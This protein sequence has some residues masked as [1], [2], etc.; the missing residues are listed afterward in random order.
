MAKLLPHAAILVNPDL[1]LP[2]DLV[3]QPDGEWHVRQL[4]RNGSAPPTP[5]A[6]TTAGATNAGGQLQG[7]LPRPRWRAALR[8]ATYYFGALRPH[9]QAAGVG[10]HC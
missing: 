8:P 5:R 1:W 6:I 7:L 3:V 9:F 4:P 2:I 10:T